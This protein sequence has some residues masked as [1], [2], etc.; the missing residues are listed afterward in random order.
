MEEQKKNRKTPPITKK[1]RKYWLIG[2]LSVILINIVAYFFYG[3]IDWTRDQRYSIT[4]A[5]KQLLKNIDQPYDI[6]VFLTGE[7]LPAAFKRLEHSTSALLSNFQSISKNK[8]RYRFVDPM[9]S[10]TMALQILNE[11]RMSGLPITISAGKK[12][13]QQKMVFPWALVSTKDANGEANYFPVFLQE[14]NTPELSRTVLNKSEMLLEYNLANAIHQVSKKEKKRL[15]Y[16]TGNE[17]QFD[18]SISAALTTL[19]RFYNVDTFNLQQNDWIPSSYDA[20]IINRPM[21]AFEELDKLKIDQYLMSGKSLFLNIDAVTGSL[22]SFQGNTQFNSMVIDLGL[23]DLFFNYGFRIN[24]N[25]IEDAVNSVGIPLTASGNN[26]QPVMYPWVYYPVLENA[27]QHPIVNNLS[28]I[29]ARFVSSI[30]LNSNDPEIQKTPLLISSAYSKLTAAPAPIL[31][32]AAIVDVN[33]AEYKIKNALAAV[34]LEGSFSS[35]YAER[36]PQ[37]V[38]EYLEGNQKDFKSKAQNQAKIIVVADG[39]LMFNEFS[40]K[41]G[42]SDMGVYLYS[43]FKFDNKSFMLNSLE[44]LTDENHL[45]GARTKNFEAYLLDP[46]RLKDER[47]NWQLLNVGGPIILV[48]IFGFVYFLIRKKRFA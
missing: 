16:L 21:K 5:T 46:K 47:S 37:E 8:I 15:A 30:D 28:G 14:S 11:F 44:Y 17:E 18:V 33:P 10:D 35:L 19:F 31:L 29:L 12:G 38:R 20:V 13:T 40:E 23:N 42:P 25:I 22:D 9:G 26:A 43:D 7:D 34:L 4:P 2:L 1:K 3:Q 39:Q 32:D 48:L 6:T 27:S 41:N 24:T 45:L 36:K